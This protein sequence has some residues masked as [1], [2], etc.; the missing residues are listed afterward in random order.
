MQPTERFSMASASRLAT[1]LG[2]LT[3]THV[4]SLTVVLLSGLW[5][6][7]GEGLGTR[8]VDDLGGGVRVVDDLGGGF[9]CQGCG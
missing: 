5:M 7:W 1:R 6:T 8:V 9:R 3:S 4:S 2:W